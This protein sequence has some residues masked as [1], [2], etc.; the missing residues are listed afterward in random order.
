MFDDAQ[1][2]VILG[3]DKNLNITAIPRMDGSDDKLLP[4]VYVK[5]RYD[6]KYG[7]NLQYVEK[8]EDIM[9][10]IPKDGTGARF[11]QAPI[12]AWIKL[13]NMS[14]EQVE[15]IKNQVKRNNILMVDESD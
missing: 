10:L 12:E 11:C 5:D 2:V 4:L 1:L 13:F 15:R 8:V 6:S 9:L 14:D 7:R 3:R